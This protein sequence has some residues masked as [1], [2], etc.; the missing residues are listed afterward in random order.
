MNS[1]IFTLV[2]SCI[3]A[4]SLL[5]I[6]FVGGTTLAEWKVD[7]SKRIQ[8][9]RQNDLKTQ[10]P[11][12][13]GGKD[14]TIFDSLTSSSAQDKSQ[15]LIILNTEN[16]FLPDTIKV[17]EGSRYQVHVVNINEKERNVSF[18]MDAF[19]EH[20]AT[21]FGKLKTFV[22]TPKKEG[23]YSFFCPETSAQG[24][25]VVLNPVQAPLPQE[26]V[27]LVPTTTD[28]IMTP[29]PSS[30]PLA[31]P[32]EKE[33]SAPESPSFPLRMPASQG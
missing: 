2:R 19:S 27:P 24:R 13:I 28:P 15:E 3:R 33:E 7:W 17:K 22:I 18:V 12:D 4:L 1:L 32:T 10:S 16:G 8:G 26:S 5:M 14:A 21:F 23:V 9:Q 25:M 29:S 20:H 30:S 6:L 11:K 31:T